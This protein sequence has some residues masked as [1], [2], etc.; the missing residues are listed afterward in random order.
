MITDTSLFIG[1]GPSI[2]WVVPQWRPYIGIDAGGYSGSSTLPA[3]AN[4]SL[5]LF[6]RFTGKLTFH[7]LA[8]ALGF[9]NL[10]LYADDN[11]RYLSETSHLFN[12]LK[13]GIN[14]GFTKDVGFGLEYS[15]GNDAPKFLK[16]Q[17]LNAS[18][19]LKF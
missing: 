1:G 5:W 19:T 16:E 3:D 9:D 15:Y 14:L 11:L 8:T 18:L 13:A 17:M 12:Y 2:G 7:K 10:Y 4:V 6:A